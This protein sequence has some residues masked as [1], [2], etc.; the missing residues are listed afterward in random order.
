MK[1]LPFARCPCV[2]KKREEGEGRNFSGRVIYVIRNFPCVYP[3][4]GGGG[5]VRLVCI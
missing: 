1:Y 3:R 5:E 4:E 2:G